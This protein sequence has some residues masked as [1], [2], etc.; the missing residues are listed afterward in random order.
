MMFNVNDPTCREL[1]Y[2]SASHNV[3]LRVYS[4]C[5]TQLRNHQTS[6]MGYNT[7]FLKNLLYFTRH[8]T[9]YILCYILLIVNIYIGCNYTIRAKI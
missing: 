1:K 9:T 8:T 5:V 7:E 6:M 3:P 2:T 4:G